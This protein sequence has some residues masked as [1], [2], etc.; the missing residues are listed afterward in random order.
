M[1]GKA[2]KYIKQ[3]VPALVMVTAC[4]PCCTLPLEA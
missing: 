2:I 3:E 4:H 1:D